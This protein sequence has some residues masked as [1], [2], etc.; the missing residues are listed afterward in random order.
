MLKQALLTA[1]FSVL[2]SGDCDFICSIIVDNPDDVIL[3]TT[4][5]II[6]CITFIVK[7]FESISFNNAVKML[8][9]LNITSP[10]PL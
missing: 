2:L 4:F 8:K 3:K 9:K 10:A 5:I 1:I 6:H 7:S